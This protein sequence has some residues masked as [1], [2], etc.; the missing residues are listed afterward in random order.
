MILICSSLFLQ[1]GIFVS[2]EFI[3]KKYHFEPPFVVGTEGFFGS[4]MVLILCLVLTYSPVSDS[5]E[6]GSVVDGKVYI[7]HMW[8]YFR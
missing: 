4:F 3:M 5:Y 8:F 1:A 2:E 6:N 7:D